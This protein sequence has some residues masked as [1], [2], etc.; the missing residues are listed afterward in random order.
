[1]TVS[2]LLPTTFIDTLYGINKVKVVSSP[3]VDIV[4]TLHGPS[5]FDLN[6]GLEYA[7][8]GTDIGRS[9]KYFQTRKMINIKCNYLKLPIDVVVNTNKYKRYFPDILLGLAPSFNFSSMIIS[10]DYYPVVN[11]AYH[12]VY[13]PINFGNRFSIDIRAGIRYKFF[14]NIGVGINY[15]LSLNN[16]SNKILFLEDYKFQ[17]WQFYLE[18]NIFGSSQEKYPVT[19][20]TKEYKNTISL[21]ALTGLSANFNRIGTEYWDGGPRYT[22]ALNYL[23]WENASIS[24]LYTYNCMFMH[25][26]SIEFPDDG[27]G[28][29]Y[30]EKELSTLGVEVMGINKRNNS[31]KI[32]YIAGINWAWYIA[33]YMEYF[34]LKKNS[35]FIGGAPFNSFWDNKD[36]ILSFGIGFQKRHLIVKPLINI[37]F[38]NWP[39]FS[40]ETGWC[41]GMHE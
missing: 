24:I 19:P 8:T 25:S 5:I 14:E 13:D 4:Y 20:T 21:I 1:M 27:E 26:K 22:L 3:F 28:K 34:E 30:G 15:A 29:Y 11:S 37:G 38:N 33:Q 2:T 9:G 40:I 31:F 23:N 41:F 6:I 36:I 39:Y 7:R 17:Y 35:N 32:L 18:Q 12:Y 10:P 16:V